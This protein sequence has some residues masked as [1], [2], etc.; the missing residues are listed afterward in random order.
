LIEDLSAHRTAALRELLAG[1]TDVA[2]PALIFVLVKR[3]VFRSPSDSCVDIR[4]QVTDLTSSSEGIGGSPAAVAFARRHQAWVDQLSDAEG[5][6]EWLCRQSQEVLLELLTFCIACTVTT[7]QKR[8]EAASQSRYDEAD[9]LATALSLDMADWWKP[10]KSRYL[11]LVSKAQIL[12]AVSEA[13]SPQA[14]DNISG[15]KKDAMAG[16]A[17]ELLAGRRWLPEPLRTKPRAHD[18]QDIAAE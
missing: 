14:A 10:T 2:L 15:M 7:V 12:S 11:T 17:E 5:L 8:R 16:R 13:V 1:R 4:P 9:V 18:N 6:W 3:I